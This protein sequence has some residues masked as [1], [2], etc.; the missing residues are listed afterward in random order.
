MDARVT[1][2]NGGITDCGF[3]IAECGLKM[4]ERR[5][6][7]DRAGT[8]S[9]LKGTTEIL[10]HR[11]EPA[12]AGFV[13]QHGVFRPVRPARVPLSFV[14]RSQSR[15]A[16]ADLTNEYAGNPIY[17]SFILHPSSFILCS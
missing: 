3:R 9:S 7:S 17:S 1:G 12:S 15:A 5:W 14:V 8:R 10:C 2:C 13:C 4:E 6:K 11:P 16:G